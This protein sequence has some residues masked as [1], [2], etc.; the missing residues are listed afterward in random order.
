[1]LSKVWSRPVAAVVGA[2]LLIDAVA[3]RSCEGPSEALQWFN[4]NVPPPIQC[5]AR[6]REQAISFCLDYFDYTYT[7][8]EYLS[9]VTPAAASATVSSTTTTLTTVTEEQ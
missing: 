4:Y 9:T 2:A 3:G 7:T 8:T 6:M 5:V 1:M